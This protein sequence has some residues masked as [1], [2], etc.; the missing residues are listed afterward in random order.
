MAY[1][2]LSFKPNIDD[3]RES[4]ALE[5]V[6]QLINFGA[7]YVCVEP[8]ITHLAEHPL[9]K[10]DKVINNYDLIVLLVKHDQF[11]ARKSDVLSSNCE[12]LDFCGFNE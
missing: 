6:D 11:L 5:I 10:I 7:Q 2:G 9:V 4:P 12:I 3:L 1:L 8:N